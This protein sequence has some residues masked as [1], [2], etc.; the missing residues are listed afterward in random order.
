[1]GGG[2]AAGEAAVTAERPTGDLP[3]RVHRLAPDR[4]PPGARERL[5]H[6][7]ASV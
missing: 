7:L 5:Q 1:M 4:R 3:A 2:A 6:A